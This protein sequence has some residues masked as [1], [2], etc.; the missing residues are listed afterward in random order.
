MAA[1]PKIKQCWKDVGL[2]KEGAAVAERAIDHLVT[3]LS[4]IGDLDLARRILREAEFRVFH[5][6]SHTPAFQKRYKRE[7]GIK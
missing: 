7:N 2:T 1:K 3:G 4:L 6:K 5:L